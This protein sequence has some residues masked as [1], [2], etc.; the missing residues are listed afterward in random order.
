MTKG[1]ALADPAGY[2][3]RA[4]RCREQAL[5]SPVAEAELLKAAETWDELALHAESLLESYRRLQ[6]DDRSS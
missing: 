5:S 1:I 3:V 2:R 6:A 4:Q